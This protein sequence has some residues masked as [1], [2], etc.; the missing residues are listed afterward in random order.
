MRSKR[1]KRTEDKNEKKRRKS[2]KENPTANSDPVPLHADD[3]EVAQRPNS[4]KQDSTRTR[5]SLHGKFFESV[6]YWPI[7]NVNL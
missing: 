1:R 2:K 7:I 6:T 3:K 5:L 4:E